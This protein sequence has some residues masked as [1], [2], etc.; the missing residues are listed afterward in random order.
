MEDKAASPPWMA[1]SPFRIIFTYL[2]LTVYSIGNEEITD[3]KP[4]RFPTWITGGQNPENKT[5]L[6]CT[7]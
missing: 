5:F 1:Q 3:T 7:G 6:H 2:H 4:E